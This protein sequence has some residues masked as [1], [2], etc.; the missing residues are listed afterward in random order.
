MNTQIKACFKKEI[1]A[2]TRTK[3]FFILL[4]VFVGLAIFDP[5][6]IRGTSAI[7]EAVSDIDTLG[8]LLGEM[9]SYASNGVAS[10]VSD[11]ALAGMIVFIL[12]IG[13]FAGGE[14]KK[15]SIIIPR[16]S[17]LQNK[18]YLL[19]KFIV[20]P[21]AAF[22]LCM[23]AVLSAA[24]LSAEIFAEND[25]IISQIFA[26]GAILGV[27]FMMYIC[28]HLCI[29]TATGKA[30]MSAAICIGALILIPGI[31][32]LMSMGTDGNLI[33]YNPFALNMMA[34]DAVHDMPET[35]EVTVTVI[36]AFALMFV[37]YLLALFA[38][39]AKKIDNKGN[40]ILI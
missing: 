14:Q 34:L 5:L 38:Q 15:R 32:A 11:L 1:M 30:G 35:G 26:A 39:N 40:E 3:R 17:G 8:E 6:M 28:F 19:P 33:A 31:F 24:V 21:V 7:M 10:L 16:T 13:S 29:G 9:T 2:F 20:Y 25:L 12:L 23:L 37:C 4:C 36:I 18:A 27:H 22:V